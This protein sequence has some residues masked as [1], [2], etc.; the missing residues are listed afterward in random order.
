M[1]GLILVA[2]NSLCGMAQAADLVIKIED[3]KK[4]PVVDAVVSLHQPNLPAR[5]SKPTIA[6]IDQRQREF[7][8]YVTVVQQGTQIRFPNSDHIRHHVYSFSPIKRFDLQLYKGTTAAPI[9]FDQAGVAVLGC[10]IHDWML[11]YVK[12]VDTPYF[13]QSTAKGVVHLSNIPAGRYELH[14]WHPRRQKPIEVPIS[15]G[16]TPQQWVQTLSY[17]SPDPRQSAPIEKSMYD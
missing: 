10:N 11:A 7:V 3:P 12:V 14:I 5:V 16:E 9:T 1:R 6:V 2:I 13:G 17:D 4:R 15:V 8:P